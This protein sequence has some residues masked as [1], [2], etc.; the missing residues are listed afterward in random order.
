MFQIT[1][2]FF[3][4]SNVCNGQFYSNTVCISHEYDPMLDLGQMLSNFVNET[5]NSGK[6]L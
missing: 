2:Y 3:Y 1:P 6:N 4:D 5:E